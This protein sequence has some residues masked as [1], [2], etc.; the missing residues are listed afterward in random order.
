MKKILSKCIIAVLLMAT[1]AVMA[2]GTF[3][4]KFGGTNTWVEFSFGQ[5]AKAEQRFFNYGTG[6]PNYYFL[7]G[8]DKESLDDY[9]MSLY[10]DIRTSSSTATTWKIKSVAGGSLKFTL[11]GGSIPTGAALALY[12]ADGNTKVVDVAANV[13]ATLNPNSTYYIQYTEKGKTAIPIAP[14]NKQFYMKRL[15]K[16]KLVINASDLLPSGYTLPSGFTLA[17]DTT[18][19]ALDADSEVIASSFA[20]I[21][22]N[23]NKLTLTLP[24][25]ID[26]K[27]TTL[28]FFCWFKATSGSNIS[29]SGK[30]TVF[31]M[32]ENPY[33]SL[34]PEGPVE[35]SADGGSAQ[36]LGLAFEVQSNVSWTVR[37]DCDWIVPSTTE[38]TNRAF[39]YYDIAP[40]TSEEEREGHL[41]VESFNTSPATFT[42]TQAGLQAEAFAVTVTKGWN[43]ISLKHQP[44]DEAITSLL[45]KYPVLTINQKGDGYEQVSSL[46]PGLPY[47]VYATDNAEEQLNGFAL[48][49][50]WEQP[51]ITNGKWTFIG[52]ATEATQ[53]DAQSVVWEW[54]TAAQSLTIVDSYTVGKAYMIFKEAE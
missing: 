37:S 9:G 12:N 3:E 18:A 27:I 44:N 16:E 6:I 21:A 13:T 15:A 29:T 34:V 11:V 25:S 41:I 53:P 19:C 42:I 33:L 47:W 43:F 2:A 8:G 51:V 14:D 36:E 17:G 46:A 5:A 54:D 45:E 22:Y 31:L 20:T 40:N 49:D 1:S 26:T 35:V 48:Q 30:V 24:T 52:I 4:F 10:R 32:S 7:N 39:V 38:G 50:S 28:Q 23:N